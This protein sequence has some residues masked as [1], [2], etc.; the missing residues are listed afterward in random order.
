M[1]RTAPAL[2]FVLASVLPA[3]AQTATPPAPTPSLDE[4]LAS[5]RQSI[6]VRDGRLAGAG[7]DTLR[8]A[9]AATPYVLIGEDHGL[10]EI[11]AFSSAVFRELAARG[12][13]DLV[14]EVGPE[15][16]RRLTTTLGARDPE[17]E[18]RTWVR[19]YPFSLAFYDLQQE[20]AFLREARAAAGPGLRVTGVD[21][22][23]M[24]A[25]RMLLESI[26]TKDA[27]LP[28]LLAQEHAAYEQAVAS[29]NPL[30][31]FLM[32]GPADALAALRDRLAAAKRPR[33]AAQVTA[34]LDSREIYGL[35]SSSG[36]LSNV[37]RAGLMKRNYVAQLA[38][39][40]RA[41]PPPTL[42][43]FGALHVMKALNTLQSREIG[44]YVAEIADGLGTP[45]VHVLVIAARGQQRRFAG[46]GKPYIA[47]PVDQVGPG[48]SDF[49]YAK[50][51]FD[52]ALG[53]E[54]WSLFDFRAMRRWSIRRTDLDPWLVRLLFGFDLAV[55]I[56]EGTPSDQLR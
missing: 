21:Q 18:V 27:A 55:V 31:L 20:L 5:V 42:Y 56:P 41:V 24:G 45:S 40:Q 47:A 16:G 13:R 10:R 15:A 30:D 14:V 29:G 25:G 39:A 11:P 17:A 34:L 1:R 52:R 9:M 3:S 32:T 54:G 49:P 8:A 50:P 43:K 28:G 2:A 7:G 33:E 6:A 38:P 12:T 46:V 35:N 36:F 51:M 4:M 26:A 44:N 22:E 37:T 23:L 53:A 19:R 48:V